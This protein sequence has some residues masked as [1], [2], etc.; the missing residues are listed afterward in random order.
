METMLMAA[1]DAA[2][3]AGL[4]GPGDLVALT[5]GVAVGVSGGTDLIRVVTA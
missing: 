2:R 1:V 4:V 5:A 3:A